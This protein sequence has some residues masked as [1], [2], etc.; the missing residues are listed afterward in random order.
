MRAH[1]PEAHLAWAVEDRAKGLL[2]GRSDLDA[3]HVF[4][5]KALQRALPR[6]F[7]LA[8]AFTP[9]ARALRQEPFD[10]VLDL[11][12]N[13]KSGAVARLARSSC[14]FGLPA[15][16][17]REGNAVFV[18]HHAGRTHHLHK[19]ERNLALASHALGTPLPYVAPGFP[20]TPEVR[21]QADALL[22]AAELSRGFVV[23]HPGTSGFGAFKRWPADRFAALGRRLVEGGD[24][25]V[26]TGSPDEQPLAEA[27]AA[28]MDGCAT[29]LATPSL[30]VLAEVIAR[31]G[32][33]VAGDT[34]PLH[35]A[36]LLH[37][38]LLG[39]FGPKDPA[40]YAPYGLRSDARPGT[41]PVVTQA[42]V[43]CRPCTL[44]QC[45]APLCMT[46]MGVE[47][48]HAAVTSARAAFA[49]TRL[50]R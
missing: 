1:F 8:T 45:D 4:P 42:D 30:P 28:G 2:L 27:V 21:A 15:R 6:P 20:R 41:L 17:A 32:F 12:G 16:E 31:A 11:Q 38:P 48:V 43:A 33:F 47:D 22:E 26:I 25:V 44:R 19:V 34:G 49:D 39:L 23:L 14:R 46:T 3:L 13:L 9:F 40:V 50:E 5:R 36:A 10:L 18:R 7:A 35:L 29:V 24:T 37:T